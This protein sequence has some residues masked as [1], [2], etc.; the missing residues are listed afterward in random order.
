MHKSVHM[1]T[2]RLHDVLTLRRSRERE[3]YHKRSLRQRYLPSTSCLG[4]VTAHEGVAKEAPT[5]WV[6]CDGR[7]DAA[8]LHPR[9]PSEAHSMGFYIKGERNRRSP[10]GDE[11]TWQRSLHG[12]KPTLLVHHEYLDT[13]LGLYRYHP[14]I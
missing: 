7:R 9:L 8:G 6:Y 13:V 3:A 10:S 5:L 11:E 1:R 2:S 14:A 12:L 4:E